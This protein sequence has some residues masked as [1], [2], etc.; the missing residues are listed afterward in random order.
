MPGQTVDQIVL[1]LQDPDGPGVELRLVLLEP[2]GLAERRGRG[3]HVAADL[4]EIIPAVAGA[5]RV[6]NGQRAG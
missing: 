4:I 1:R 2:E 6:G 3:E 5:Q